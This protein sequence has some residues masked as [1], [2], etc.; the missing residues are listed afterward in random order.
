MLTYTL[1]VS[2]V[3]TDI[4]KIQ[5]TTANDVRGNASL[6]TSLRLFREIDLGDLA[7][8]LL[9]VDDTNPQKMD[10]YDIAHLAG[11]YTMLETLPQEIADCI[12][13]SLPAQDRAKLSTV[14]KAYKG[15]T[16]QE[17]NDF[18]IE[19]VSKLYEALEWIVEVAR[20]DKR[21]VCSLKIIDIPLRVEFDGMDPLHLAPKQYDYSSTV[22][23]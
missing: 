19:K 22:A 21:P 18:T 4:A 5:N 9:V 8:F 20:R 1:S 10:Y 23:F 7:C 16:Q 12:L 17:W 6:T 3:N 11:E 13:D 15:T 2:T 14:S